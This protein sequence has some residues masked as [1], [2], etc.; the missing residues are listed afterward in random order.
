MKLL[1][2]IILLLLLIFINP[3]KNFSR[4]II[5]S[6]PTM[7][8][9]RVSVF[10]DCSGCYQDYIRTEITFVNY[11]RDITQA[12]VY[13]FI[14]AQA[15]GSGGTNFTLIILGKQTYEGRND[16]LNYISK[17][18]ETDD[19]VRRGLVNTLKLGLIPYIYKTELAQNIIVSFLE[20]TQPIIMKDKWKSWVFNNNVSGSVGGEK[21][22]NAFYINA[23][24]S[25]DKITP[26]WKINVSGGI[27][28]NEKKFIINDNS[29]KS[30]SEGKSCRSLVVRSIS[31]HWSMGGSVGAS[32]S[33]YSNIRLQ[34]YAMPAIE[35]DIFPYAEA[36]RKQCR[37]LYKIGYNHIDYNEETIYYKTSES[38]FSESLAASLEVKKEW[39]SLNSSIEAA[40]YFQDFKKNHISFWNSFYF[41]LFEGFALSVSGRVSVIHDQLSLAKQGASTEQILLQ[42]TQLATTYSYAGSVGFNYTFGSIYNSVVNPRFNGQ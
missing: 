11:V 20:Q 40:H 2:S 16:T 5:D 36:T 29:I 39:G 25:A 38:L 37:F 42:R 19:V 30:I 41:R 9:N 23:S 34:L 21:S 26:Q 8:D 35:Y 32:S 28:Y 17:K 13:V 6:L 3:S 1:N 12:D 14:T 31:N 33:S 10:I 15:T 24:T 7:K 22:S 27:N 4:D 18:S